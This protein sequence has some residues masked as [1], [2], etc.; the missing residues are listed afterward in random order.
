MELYGPD[1]HGFRPG[2]STL[3]SILSM[4]ERITLALDDNTTRGVILLS[5]DMSRA[6]DRI[7]HDILIA[8]LSEAGLPTAFT[9]W[10]ANY[11][12]GR[13]QKVVLHKD[14]FSDKLPVSSGVPQGSILSPFLFCCYIGTLGKALPISN[15]YKYA[16]DVIVTA[17]FKTSDEVRFIVDSEVK[18]ISAWWKANGIVLNEQKTKLLVIDKNR[19]DASTCIPSTLPQSAA[20]S[21]LGVIFQQSLKWDAHAQHISKKAS[22]RIYL[23]KVL[24]RIPSITKADLF[25][26][27]KHLILSIIEYN[28]PLFIGATR[29][30]S[31]LLERVQRRCHKII[32]GTNCDKTCL[33]PL[34]ER[35]EKQAMKVF[36]AALSNK[37]HVL[38]KFTPPTLHHSSHLSVQYCRTQR[39]ANSFFPFC[40]RLHNDTYSFK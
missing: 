15:I 8:R 22:Q 10:I 18:N 39:R 9:T 17:P 14:I 30:Y 26:V 38:H 29:K 35:R 3:T 12:S 23:L 40:T 2:H 33:V 11:L 32:C 4:H 25:I 27:Y 20:M 34:K 21:I 37:T 31:D 7:P 24:S 36:E 19:L 6:F 5:F 28:S 16:D 13:K 1:Q